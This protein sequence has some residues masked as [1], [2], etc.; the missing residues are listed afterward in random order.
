MAHRNERIARIL[1]D[2]KYALFRRELQDAVDL[3]EDELDAPDLVEEVA[4]VI[5]T[6]HRPVLG[7]VDSINLEYLHR[8]SRWFAA[9]NQELYERSAGPTIG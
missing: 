2:P 5:A 9:R 7:A 4:P 3:L 8:P 1:D 6:P